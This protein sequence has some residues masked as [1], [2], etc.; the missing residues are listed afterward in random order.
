MVFV[1]YGAHLVVRLVMLVIMGRE[2]GTERRRRAGHAAG[3][4]RAR[5][6]RRRLLLLLL[7]LLR[8]PVVACGRLLGCDSPSMELVLSCCL[9]CWWWWGAGRIECFMP[10]L[11]L[12]PFG[13]L[14]ASCVSLWL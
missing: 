14:P 6:R 11:P 2:G 4:T 10:A 13:G 3:R 1:G 8:L 12:P 5:R 9:S 7:L